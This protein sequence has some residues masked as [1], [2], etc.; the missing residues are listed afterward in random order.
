MSSMRIDIKWNAPE[1]LVM[2]IMSFYDFSYVARIVHRTV[3]KTGF[4]E[5][6]ERIGLPSWSL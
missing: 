4:M 2:R 6:G 3:T 5:N 1:I